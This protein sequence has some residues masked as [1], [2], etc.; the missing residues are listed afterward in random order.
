MANDGILGLF[1]GF[2][3]PGNDRQLRGMRYPLPC[4]GWG[5]GFESLRPLQFPLMTGNASGPIEG[6]LRHVL[7]G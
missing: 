1:L 3:A 2:L 6:P 4:Q 7:R 5:R